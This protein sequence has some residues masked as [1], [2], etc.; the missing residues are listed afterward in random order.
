M[1]TSLG[2]ILDAYQS[3]P[4]YSGIVLD[5][6]SRT[7]LFGDKPIHVA[8]TRGSVA[9]LAVLVESGADVNEPGEHGYRPLHNSVEQGHLLAVH[10]LL[11]NGADKTQKNRSGQTPLDLAELLEEHEIAGLLA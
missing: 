1:M 4:E 2:E 11:N 7:S 9:D 5:G 3:L 6:V 10:W 8:A